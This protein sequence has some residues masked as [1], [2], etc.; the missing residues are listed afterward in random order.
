MHQRKQ[1]RSEHNGEQRDL[2]IAPLTLDCPF[3]GNELASVAGG[4]SRIRQCTCGARVYSDGSA[5]PGRSAAGVAAAAYREIR[6]RLRREVVG[7]HD[8]QDRLALMAARA[9]HAGGRQRGLIIGPSGTGKT[10]MAVALGHAVGCRVAMWDVSVSSEAGW[11]GVDAN[12]VLAELYD[13]CDQDVDW[14]SRSILILDEIDKLAVRDAKGPSKQHR[15][16][17]Q[18]S[19]LGILG[20]GV[21]VRFPEHGDRGP[22]VT[23]VTDD[24]LIIGLGVFDGLPAEPDPAHLVSYGYTPEF[25]SRFGIVMV[26][27]PLTA[28]DLVGVLRREVDRLG[29]GADFGF[30]IR[31]P[32][33]VLRYVADAVLRAGDGVTP[34][35]GIGWIQAAV[36]AAL[37]RLLDLE[38]APGTVYPLQPDDVTV[39]SRIRGPGRR[40]ES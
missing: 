6:Q 35:A 22:A 12:G 2:V 1:Y 5:P 29:G 24:M 9:L 34:R 13:S 4:I 19:L 36:D 16:G 40:Q 21:P 37:L 20:G 30:K 38:A 8:I 25:A 18:K 31:V 14:M 15:L 7:H 17:Q 3:C 27:P 28:S 26:L 11:A 23:V 10:T 39:P 32:E 33:P